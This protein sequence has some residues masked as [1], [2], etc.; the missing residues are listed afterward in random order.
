LHSPKTQ[1]EE[2]LRLALVVEGGLA[3][4]ALAGAWLFRI[5]LAGMLPR[6]EALGQAIITGLGAVV[7]LLVLYA[8]LQKVSWRPIVRLRRQVLR[9]VRLLFTDARV[10]QLALVS[11]LAGV[12]E[13]LAFRGVLQP[14]LVR[15]TGEV[16]GIGLT[17]FL[18]GL[19]HA[20]SRTYLVLA[21]LIGLFFGLLSYKT[22]EI[23]SSIVA[24]ALYDFVVLMWLLRRR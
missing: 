17:S 24:H 2:T 19:G 21:T 16:V 1:A 20:L 3:V 10:W 5:P 4:L 7:P 13:E 23:A 15:W 6:G 9:L 8:V 18:F 11:I 22:G 12:G 14:L